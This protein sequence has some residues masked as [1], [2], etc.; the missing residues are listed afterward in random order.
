AGNEG[1][2]PF[3]EICKALS[4]YRQ[5]HFNEA[6]EW[7]QKSIGSGSEEAQGHAYGV[8]AMADWQ[9]GKKDE[10]RGMIANGEKLAPTVMPASVAEDM[11]DAWL[12]WLYARIQLDEATALIGPASPIER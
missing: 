2:R 4:E 12:A 3:F 7:A 6:A 10:A 1:A 5:G 11:G 9:L 8:L